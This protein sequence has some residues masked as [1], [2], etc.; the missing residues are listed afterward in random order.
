MKIL[1]RWAWDVS[2]VRL[3]GFL[4]SA[5]KQFYIEKES[6]KSP[7]ELHTYTQCVELLSITVFGFLGK[8]IA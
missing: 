2:R 3:C 5:P 6:V 7:V 1:T 4:S 8:T